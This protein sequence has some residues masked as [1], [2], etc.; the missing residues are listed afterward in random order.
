MAADVNDTLTMVALAGPLR[1]IRL[2]SVETGE[3]LFEMK[4]HTDWVYD[5]E[6]S[7]DGVLLATADRSGGLFVWE[8]ATAREYLS[9]RGH[10]GAVFELA[11]HPRGHIL[12]SA[13]GAMSREITLSISERLAIDRR[14]RDQG[15]KRTTSGICA[16]MGLTA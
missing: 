2:Y 4:K 14:V 1:M 6:F 3:K 5:C 7:P 16:E 11:F 15:C 12:A 9:L 8:A 10:N 13:S